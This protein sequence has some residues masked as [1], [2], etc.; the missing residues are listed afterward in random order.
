MAKT[1]VLDT[2]TKGT[3]AHMVPLESVT[4][5]SSEVEPIFVPRKPAPQEPEPVGPRPPHKFKVID[6]MTRQT[7]LED[8]NTRQAVDLLGG[9]RSNIDVNVYTWDEAR[10]RWRLLS[11]AE[12]RAL[13]DLAHPAPSPEASTVA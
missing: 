3:G 2:E 6:L 8:A 1:W 10:T 9:V 5:R 12:Q 11:G 7:L 13:W 4:K